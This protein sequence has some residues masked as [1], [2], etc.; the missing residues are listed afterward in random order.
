[1]VSGILG[2]SIVLVDQSEVV[3]GN[4]TNPANDFLDDTGN[5]DV[6]PG[7]LRPFGRVIVH[8]S[9]GQSAVQNL[10]GVVKFWAVIN[11]VAIDFRLDLGDSPFKEGGAEG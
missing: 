5:D 3:V 8:R 7:L 6:I 11:S 2:S 10:V 1:V 4:P 9:G